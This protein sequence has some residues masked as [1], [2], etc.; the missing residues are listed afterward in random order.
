MKPFNPLRQLARNPKWQITYARAKEISLD[1]FL[2]KIDLTPIQIT[3]LQW[4]EIYHSL[5]IELCNPETKL[6]REIINDDYRCDAYL[7]CRNLKEED[8]K[9]IVQDS[10]VAGIPTIIFTGRQ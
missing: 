10:V 9:P 5:E 4:L 7:Y 8:K 2:N 1:L 3:F 6:N